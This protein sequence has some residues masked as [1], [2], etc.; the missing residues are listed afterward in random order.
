MQVV[1]IGLAFGFLYLFRKHALKMTTIAIVVP[2]CAGAIIGIAA[3]VCGE[4]LN[5]ARCDKDE[6]PCPPIPLQAIFRREWSFL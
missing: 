1:G 2:L 6:N 4:R 5:V 3:L